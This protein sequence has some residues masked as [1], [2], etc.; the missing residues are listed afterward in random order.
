MFA[1]SAH[2]Y[3]TDFLRRLKLNEVDRA[4]LVVLQEHIEL[5]YHLLVELAGRGLEVFPHSV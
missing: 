3:D 1:L 5:I 4:V 2:A